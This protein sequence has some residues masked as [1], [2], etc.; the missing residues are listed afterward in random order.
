MLF[1]AL[2]LLTILLVDDRMW[3]GKMKVEFGIFS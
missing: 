3:E 1:F 2:Y